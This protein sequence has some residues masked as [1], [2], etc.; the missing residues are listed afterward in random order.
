VL[1]NRFNGLVCKTIQDKKGKVPLIYIDA[2]ISVIWESPPSQ[3]I[4]TISGRF[5]GLPNT[6]NC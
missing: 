1:A 6:I 5:G 4:A 3:P 2:F